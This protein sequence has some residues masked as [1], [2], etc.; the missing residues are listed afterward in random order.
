MRKPKRLLV[1]VSSVCLLLGILLN[2]C[3]GSKPVSYFSN[4]ELDTAKMNK[5]EIPEQVIQKGDLLGITIYSDNPDAT[6]IFNQ[7]GN[8][9]PPA[10]NTIGVSKSVTSSVGNT[11]SGSP[12]YQVDNN[13]NIFL[14]AI[15]V[16]HVEGLTKDQLSKAIVESLGQLGV[17][18]NPY[19]IVRY[20]NFKITVLGEVRS[21]GVF[22]LPSEK[23]SILEAIGLAGDITDFG[24]KDRILLIR[25]SQ[26]SRTYHIMNLTD[27]TIFSSDFFYLKQNDVLVVKADSRKPTAMDQ[28][29]LQYIALAA[30]VVSSL[31]I[32][33]TLFK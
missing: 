30:T 7:A 26:G 32:F 20:N 16:L 19:C 18:T 11:G 2:S 4:G 31:A 5:V 15:G 29:S 1:Q 33:I 17:L 21:P 9:A 14:H 8:A 10:S 23:A 3:F 27:P 24:L 28:Q 13:G 25:E 6:M 12:S 22:T